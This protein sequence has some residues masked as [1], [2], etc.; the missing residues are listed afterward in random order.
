MSTTSQSNARSSESQPDMVVIPANE[1]RDVV[2]S[3]F[4][5]AGADPSTSDRVTEGLVSSNLAGVETHG[6]WR[7][8]EYVQAIHSGDVV[9]TAKPEILSQTPTTALVSGNWNF[10]HVAAKYAT[11][12]AIEK[13]QKQNIA[14]TAIVKTYH[15]GRIGE[16]VEMA[17]ARGLIGQCWAG[18]FSEE[19]P[20][21]VPY[22]GRRRALHTNPFSMSFPV[23]N[24]S[25]MMF[26]FATAAVSGIKVLY[27]R[28][29]NKPLPPNCIVDKD[30]NPTTNAAD[31]Y[32]GGGL[33]PFG[34][35]KGYGLMMAAEFLGM[36][37][38][39]SDNYSDPQRGNAIYRHSGAAFIVFKPD[40]FRPLADYTAQAE[41]VC[42]RIRQVPPAPGFK[43]VLV[44]GD[45][46]ARTR[47]A[48]LRDGIPLT[49]ELWNKISALPKS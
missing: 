16:Y 8:P 7:V 46:E 11:E 37:L 28:E 49:R 23:G 35:H 13:A 4:K 1:L 47:A 22:G 48:R 9:P 12:L 40:V 15:I 36:V 44:P 14:I 2:R 3:T 6:V 18:G 32:E 39:G 10:G 30:G 43:E 38:T 19:S 29:Q 27:A 26:D 42:T 21:A 20:A 17:A 31:Y 5:A 34:M 33:L 24:G 45:P 25:P 41:K